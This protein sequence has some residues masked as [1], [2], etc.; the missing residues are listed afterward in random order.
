VRVC[1]D[2]AVAEDNRK[3]A[4]NAS[5]IAGRFYRNQGLI[6]QSLITGCGKS[7]FVILCEAKN[8]SVHWT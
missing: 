2:N 4:K 8:L 7:T 1:P 6:Q 5:F 3:A